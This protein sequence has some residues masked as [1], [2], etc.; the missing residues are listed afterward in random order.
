[1]I[2]SSDAASLGVQLSEVLNK[3]NELSV[4]MVAQRRMIDQLVSSSHSGVQND[5]I[6]NDDIQLE[7]DNQPTHTC[8]IQT[9]FVSSFTN[10]QKGAFTYFNPSFPHT[11]LGNILVNPTNTKILQNYP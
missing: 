2:T 8:T 6:P 11:Y 1:M 4:E 10:F 3:V 9:T 5:C 7:L